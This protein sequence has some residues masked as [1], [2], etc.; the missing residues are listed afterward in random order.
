MSM[1]PLYLDFVKQRPASRLGLGLMVL[2]VLLLSINLFFWAQLARES[3]L[4]KR[5]L[6][7]LQAAKALASA[8]QTN[9]AAQYVTANS[10]QLAVELA[11]NGLKP[12]VW[13]ALLGQLESSITQDIALLSIEP[14]VQ[15]GFVQLRAEAKDYPAILTYMT[16][17]DQTKALQ[18]IHL[19][20]HEIQQDVAGTPVSFVLSAVWRKKS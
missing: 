7:S 5:Q 8:A 14:N 9:K 18:E 19:M 2:G 3:S 15:T 20:K 13:N 10:N 11:L 1:P 16:A 6:N 12:Q 17:L 4:L